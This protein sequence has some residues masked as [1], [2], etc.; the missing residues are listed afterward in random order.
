M[1]VYIGTSGW[2]YKEWGKRFYPKKM[3]A[4]EWLPY[5]SERFQTLEIN[6]SFYQLP[7][8]ET[9]AKWGKE[10]PDDFIFA[11]KMSRYLTHIKRLSEPEEPVSRFL[12]HAGKLGKKLGPILIQ[13][14]PWLQIDIDNLK[15]TLKQFPKDTRVTVEFRHQSWFTDETRKILEKHGAA[16]CMADREGKPATPLWKTAEW[17][18]LRLHIGSAS[19]RGCYRKTEIDRWASEL[20]KH[21]RSG[22]VF[23]YFNN[24]THGCALKD[25][26]RLAASIEKAGLK[27]SRVSGG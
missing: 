10:T 15:L 5:F 26:A 2:Q 16:L 18:Y 8:A 7:S 11:V 20:K 24:D 13:L 27:H 3:K 23:V 17:G 4:P 21:W 12:S 1:T 9:F 19:P 14:P 6:N 22:D 25:A